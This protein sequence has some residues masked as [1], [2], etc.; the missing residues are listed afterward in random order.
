LAVD[1][2]DWKS[3]GNETPN[4]SI[5]MKPNKLTIEKLTHK[6][7]IFVFKPGIPIIYLLWVI[8]SSL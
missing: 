1:I 6:I 4:D 5:R 3:A 8:I 2:I 7:A